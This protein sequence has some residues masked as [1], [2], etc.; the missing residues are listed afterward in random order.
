M[1]EASCVLQLQ[2]PEIS[3]VN[4]KLQL[5]VIFFQKYLVFFKQCWNKCYRF[6]SFILYN[7]FLMSP[8]PQGPDEDVWGSTGGPDS[9]LWRKP[10][11]LS[12]DPEIQPVSVWVFRGDFLSWINWTNVPVS[13]LVPVPVFKKTFSP[14]AQ[15]TVWSETNI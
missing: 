2:K 7:C 13:V 11:D 14:A 9:F 5:L 6:L 3:A 4:L 15:R 10:S 12:P 1:F 8:T